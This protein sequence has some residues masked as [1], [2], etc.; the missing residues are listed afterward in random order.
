MK[1]SDI[2]DTA[3]KLTPQNYENIFSVFEDL[4]GFYYF[5]LLRTINFPTDLDPTTYTIYNTNNGDIWPLISWKFY[6]S[7]K[8]WWLICAANQIIDPTI[9]PEVGTELKIINK[10]V[11]RDLL[12]EIRN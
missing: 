8:L 10:E 12:N 9:M 7:V 6:K 4:D 5:N 2:E 3:V 11:V 1:Y